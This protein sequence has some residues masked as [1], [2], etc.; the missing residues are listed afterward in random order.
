MMMMMMMM[1]IIIIIIINRT[2]TD[3]QQIINPFF[4]SAPDMTW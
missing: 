3:P 4:S 1:M 2:L